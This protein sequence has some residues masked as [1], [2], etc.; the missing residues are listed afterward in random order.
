[1]NTLALVV[2]VILEYKLKKFGIIMRYSILKRMFSVAIAFIVFGIID[3]GVMV[4]SGTAI[5]K[6]LGRLLGISPMASAGLGNTLSDFIGIICG[7]YIEKLIYKAFPINKTQ[8]ISMSQTILAES[9]GITLGCL[10]GM[11]PLLFM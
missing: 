10:L 3:N 5:D 4:I 9:I 11:I 7:R 6:L 8:T 2:N 1:V